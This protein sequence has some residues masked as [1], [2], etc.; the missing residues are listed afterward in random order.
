MAIRTGSILLGTVLAIVVVWTPPGAAQEADAL[1]TLSADDI[2]AMFEAV[3]NWG[4]WGEDD[5]RGTLNLITP[6]KRIQAAALVRE[7]VSVSLS[8]DLSSVESAD[9]TTPL[10]LIM[11]AQPGSPVAMDELR[12]F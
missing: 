9:N 2:D 5:Q 12:I 7:G 4:R 3:S 10:S 1:P 8:Q 11:T 6:E